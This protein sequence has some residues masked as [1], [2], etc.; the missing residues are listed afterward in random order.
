MVKPQFNQLLQTVNILIGEQLETCKEI[1][2]DHVKMLKE[3]FKRGHLNKYMIFKLMKEISQVCHS[4]LKQ[5]YATGVFE[6]SEPD[7]L[8]N[9]VRM[10]IKKYQT[11]TISGEKPP[12]LQNCPIINLEK[13]EM[14]K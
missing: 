6:K 14:A 3:N 4:Q 13:D 5:R 11:L 2:R 12:V 9:F 10:S 1:L 7:A 8:T